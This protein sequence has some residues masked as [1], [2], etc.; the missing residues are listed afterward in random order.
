MLNYS[1]KELTLRVANCLET[2]C[3]VA[4]CATLENVDA[5]RML[6]DKAA[7]IVDIT[8]YD[9]PHVVCFVV[10]LDVLDGKIH[11]KCATVSH[12]SEKTFQKICFQCIA[13]ILVPW[14]LKKDSTST[15]LKLI[16]SALWR[17]WKRVWLITKRSIDRNDPVQFF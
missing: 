3:S 14:F 6:A 1:E 15:K 4:S 8:V 5:S 2:L 9:D 17:S 10:R 12:F 11:I 7:D 16:F 13:T